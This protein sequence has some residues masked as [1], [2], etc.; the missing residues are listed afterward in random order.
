M[1]KPIE[2]HYKGYRFRSRLEARWAVFFETLGWQ[3]EYEPEGFDLEGTWYL[4]DFKVYP[5]NPSFGDENA[6]WFEV[7]PHMSLMGYKEFKKIALFTKH[8][9]NIWILDGVPSFGA[10]IGWYHMN[11][12]LTGNCIQLSSLHEVTEYYMEYSLE[13]QN[14]SKRFGD[15][16]SRLR[17][18]EK[19][20]WY[21]EY[22]SD[23]DEHWR[24]EM[25]K[26]IFAAR[27][28]RFENKED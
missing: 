9:G 6:Y 26:A 16:L 20:I 1:I 13:N 5:E 12:G 14:P 28:A 22:G 27:S 2:T 15:V 11:W 23:I 4:P 25:T 17:Q 24:P 7:K 10:Y 8:I 3:W 21:G 19:G 18:H